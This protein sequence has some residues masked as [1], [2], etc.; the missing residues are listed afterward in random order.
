MSELS[1]F[2]GL[3]YT[4]KQLMSDKNR[5]KYKT[6]ILKAL[7]AFQAIGLS[8]GGVVSKGKK[9]EDYGLKNV[10]GGT[11]EIPVVL[12]A[13]ERVLTPV[14]NTMW[15]KWTANMPKLM[16]I[17]PKIEAVSKMPEVKT[18][19]IASSVKVDYGNVNINLPNVK[20]Y[21][22]FMKCAQKDPNFNRMIDYMVDSHLK[23]FGSMGKYNVRF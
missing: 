11:D 18:N 7:Q 23:G 20:N 3:N 21:Q 14:Q 15:E 16:N 22:D 19:N 8:K 5:S 1:K 10:S 12:T 6:N 9:L 2:L 17:A 13:G 4:T